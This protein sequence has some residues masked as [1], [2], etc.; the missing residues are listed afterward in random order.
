M[1]LDN[2]L[3]IVKK[4]SF[5]DYKTSKSDKTKSQEKTN[6]VS[7]KKENNL[8]SGVEDTSVDKKSILES[9]EE[10]SK[11]DVDTREFDSYL[12]PKVLQSLLSD[13][14]FCQS[15]LFVLHVT[16]GYCIMDL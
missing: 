4:A 1:K 9:F 13:L 2:I 11:S 10:L 6:S 12:K 14:F 16:Y 7:F 8:F 3:D 15:L 5:A